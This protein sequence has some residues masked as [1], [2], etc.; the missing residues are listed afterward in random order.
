MVNKI[1]LKKINKLKSGPK[2]Y[3]AIFEKETK[4]GNMKE[5]KRKFGAFGMSDYT[6]HKDTERRNR[7]ISRHKKDLRTNDP[8]RPGFLSMY[9]LWNKKEYSAS[10]SDY[11]KRLSK[12][13][14]TGK[15]PTSIPKSPLQ[16]RFGT[17][18]NSFGT[19]QN[20][21]N[22][23]P[24][25]LKLKTLDNF[26][27]CKD[28]IYFCNINK[29]N[30]R[31]C[32]EYNIYNKFIKRYMEGISKSKSSEQ[33]AIN[34]YYYKLVK[35]TLKN[36]TNDILRKVELNDIES[37]PI[38][39]DIVKWL[40]LASKHLTKQELETNPYIELIQVIFNSFYVRSFEMEGWGAI[41]SDNWKIDNWNKSYNSFQQILDKLGIQYTDNDYFYESDTVEDSLDELI[42]KAFSSNSNFGLYYGLNFGLKSPK[43]Q[44]KVPDNVKNKA[45]Y[46]KIK[47]KIRKDVDKKNRRWGAYDS[48]RLVREYKEKGGKYSGNKKTTS[49]LSRWY[50]EKWID[51][52]A[53]PKKKSCGR[54]KSNEKI[55][56]CRPSIRVD[57]KTPKLIQDLTKAQIKSRCSKKKKNPK[58]ILRN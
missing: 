7:Y 55:A 40:Y 36:L 25:E 4:N 37:N 44:G 34:C 24:D 17:L 29:D 38:K 50:K 39:K 31:I 35:E 12:Y 11:K 1:I 41:T 3:E 42:N 2:K 57:S 48:G 18:Q 13:N 56:Y 8:T 54:N 6:I 20:S 47:N 27:D 19:L 46:L 26:K 30:R 32:K 33:F 45:L 9:I 10:V 52:C 51:A 14:K 53:W 5:I 21:F 58:K 16:N 28:V 15:F 43:S 49:D 23:L 22:L